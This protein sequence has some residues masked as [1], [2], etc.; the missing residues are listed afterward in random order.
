MSNSS[1]VKGLSIC[2]FLSYA[3]VL[4]M[5]QLKNRVFS[6]ETRTTKLDLL[7]SARI[8]LVHLPWLA[9]ERVFRRYHNRCVVGRRTSAKGRSQCDWDPMQTPHTERDMDTNAKKHVRPR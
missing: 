8:C 5:N 7:L 3:E 6:E 9:A 2:I 4:S 1:A